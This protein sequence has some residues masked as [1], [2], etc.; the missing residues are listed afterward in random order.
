[1]MTTFQSVTP[2]EATVMALS[3]GMGFAELTNAQKADRDWK[4][5]AS[6]DKKGDEYFAAGNLAM[7]KVCRERA[8]NS[9]NRAVRF[10]A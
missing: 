2:R 7:A 8:L 5:A 10:S 3:W 9:A 1:M 4:L 6:L